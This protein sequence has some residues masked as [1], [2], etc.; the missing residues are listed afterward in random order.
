[1]RITKL[2]GLR[3]IFSLMVVLYH[4]PSQ[5]MPEYF[6]DFFLIKKSHLFVEFFFVLSGFVI[7]L[8]Y[9][10]V[11]DSGQKFWN[12]IRKRFIRLYPLLLY[13][14][15]L[16]LGV[17]IAVKIL[18][19]QLAAN[20]ESFMPAIVDTV[21]TL[22]FLNSTPVISNS[23]GMNYPSWSISAEMISYL[24]FGMVMLWCTAKRQPLVM[25]ITI[26]LSM[27]LM[28]WVDLVA[29]EMNYDFLFGVA[30]CSIGFLVFHFST[31]QVR[32][33][34]WWE[35]VAFVGM[36]GL[37]YLAYVVIDTPYSGL[38]EKVIAP[39]CFGL[40]IFIV[41]NCDGFI[42][43]SMDGRIAQYFGKISYSV[44]LN[45]A[46]FLTV[47][48]IGIFN[49]LHLPNSPVFELA[50]STM[51]LVLIIVYSHFTHKIVELGGSR[52]LKRLFN[53]ANVTN[54]ISGINR[55]AIH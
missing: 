55:T 10:H 30:G 36:I 2:D 50:A 44:Y 49:V 51:I 13:S 5:F 19:P 3:G 25:A 23:Y 37:L 48:P 40:A 6:H 45:H 12:F 15:L 41:V 52:L 7:A 8:N 22:L 24:F 34:R 4:Y 54:N 14:T 20:K 39:L 32:L 26:V 11:I 28:L 47:L 31:Y 42:S 38:V 27:A 33:S 35:I 43:R 17:Q 29:D 1:M 46:L 53:N 18:F 9:R 16:F 21:D